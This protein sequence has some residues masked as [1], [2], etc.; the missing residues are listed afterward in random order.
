[1]RDVEQQ[2]RSMML[3][4]VAC[5]Q[6]NHVKI[7]AFLVDKQV[8][9]SLAPAFDVTYNYQPAGRWTYSHHLILNGKWDEFDLSDF[10]AV[11][12]LADLKRV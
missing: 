6:G 3:N 4:V 10:V 11:G 12:K 7:I 2:F 9:W 5:N 1:M 8:N